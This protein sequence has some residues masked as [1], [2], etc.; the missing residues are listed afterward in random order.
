MAGTVRPLP[1]ESSRPRKNRSRACS[2]SRLPATSS[3]DL[4]R[5]PAF[6]AVEQ[7]PE[8]VR[9]VPRRCC[10]STESRL[11]GGDLA[12]P[13]PARLYQVHEQRIRSLE[14]R[15]AMQQDRHAAELEYAKLRFARLREKYRHKLYLMT[16][17]LLIHSDRNSNAQAPSPVFP[18]DGSSAVFHVVDDEQRH[19][20]RTSEKGGR[21]VTALRD[22]GPRPRGGLTRK[23]LDA[24]SYGGSSATGSMSIRRVGQGSCVERASETYDSSDLYSCS[25]ISEEARKQPAQRRHV[26]HRLVPDDDEDGDSGGSPPRIVAA[27]HHLDP[28]EEYMGSGLMYRSKTTAETSS[29]LQD[30]QEEE[31][32]SGTV[33]VGDL[34][35]DGGRNKLYQPPGLTTSDLDGVDSYFQNSDMA[36]L[37]YSRKYDA[38]T[39]AACLLTNRYAKHGGESGQTL[40]SNSSFNSNTQP[41]GYAAPSRTNVVSHHNNRAVASTAHQT[42]PLSAAVDKEVPASGPV[43]LPSGPVRYRPAEMPPDSSSRPRTSLSASRKSGRSPH[44]GR[45]SVSRVDLFEEQESPDDNEST[46]SKRES[47]FTF[48]EAS[49]LLHRNQQRRPQSR[50]SSNTMQVNNCPGGSSPGQASTAALGNYYLSRAADMESS[51]PGPRDTYVVDSLSPFRAI[52]YVDNAPG[53][54]NGGPGPPDCGSSRPPANGNSTI[55]PVGRPLSRQQWSAVNRPTSTVP[56]RGE[57]SGELNPKRTGTMKKAETSAPSSSSSSSYSRIFSTKN[58]RSRHALNSN[59]VQAHACTGTGTLG[60]NDELNSTAATSSGAAGGHSWSGPGNSSL[61][62]R[63]STVRMPIYHQASPSARPAIHNK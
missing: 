33:E 42:R 50:N 3:R 44:F 45:A 5:P 46:S 56:V 2:L 31:M 40:Q 14:R 35:D 22:A 34:S 53:P 10:A 6:L 9:T 63:C 52:E 55:A 38:R 20:Y 7:A 24:E 4:L 19:F 25:F 43:E 15:L 8:A 23:P 18:A 58:S 16:S 11:D 57:S 12:G 48:S 37:D 30:F 27:H 41:V 32:E 54:V 36:V 21:N 61:D 39:S 49:R 17:M 28:G 26:V 60:T 13:G 1:S 51:E 29:D 59:N 47:Q 62:S